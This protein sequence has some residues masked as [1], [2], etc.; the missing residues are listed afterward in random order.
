MNR[1]KKTTGKSHTLFEHDPPKSPEDIWILLAESCYEISKV[2]LAQSTYASSLSVYFSGYRHH[3][4]LRGKTFLSEAYPRYPIE[5]FK[6]LH[7]SLFLKSLIENNFT[8]IR[9]VHVRSDCDTYFSPLFEV[10]IENNAIQFELM[11]K[12]R[13][14]EHD[15]VIGLGHEGLRHHRIRTYTDKKTNQIIRAKQLLSTNKIILNLLKNS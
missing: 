9:R 3:E 10:C 14:K 12:I 7:H 2:H 13:K 6:I 8:D 4:N 11:E 15:D 5:L 1:Q